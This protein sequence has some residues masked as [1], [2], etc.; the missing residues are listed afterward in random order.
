MKKNKNQYKTQHCEK[1][2]NTEF[3]LVRICPYLDWMRIVLR[4]SPYSVRMRENTNQ[5]KLR[6]W[7][8]FTQC[9]LKP[10]MLLLIFH[11]H[12]RLVKGRSLHSSVQ[13]SKSA[14]VT[15]LFLFI[16]FMPNNT[17][18]VKI[19]II[20]FY[21]PVWVFVYVQFI[22]SFILP[23]YCVSFFARLQKFSWRT[24]KI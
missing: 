5:K 10:I 8:L 6:I 12:I 15:T 20:T 18:L 3:F 13:Y 14:S 11:Y 2:P 19:K 1:C 24:V 4:I 16:P 17:H 9:K 21:A 7:T 22:Y 23:S